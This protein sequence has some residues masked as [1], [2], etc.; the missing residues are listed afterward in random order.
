MHSPGVVRI[1]G[2]VLSEELRVTKHLWVPRA[3]HS[4]W[5]ALFLLG[6]S[7]PIEN[8]QSDCMADLLSDLRQCRL[9][10]AHT[11]ENH[12]VQDGLLFF[13]ELTTGELET[14]T[15]SARLAPPTMNIARTDRR[16]WISLVP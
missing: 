14:P 1:I 9:L 4:V 10:V 7:H 3:A 13:T 11:L 6:S 8:G 15:K 16:S 5:A 12:T 2:C